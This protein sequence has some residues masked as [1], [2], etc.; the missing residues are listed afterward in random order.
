M[1]KIVVFQ[2]DDLV[3]RAQQ[4][5]STLARQARCS[6]V[7]ALPFC[8]AAS[9]TRCAIRASS[10]GF[11]TWCREP[12]PPRGVGVGP[13]AVARPSIRTG[14]RACRVHGVCMLYT[15]HVHMLCICGAYMVH[16]AHVAEAPRLSKAR[17]MRHRRR[18][19]RHRARHRARRRA[20]RHVPRIVR[21]AAVAWQ[22][23]ELGSHRSELRVRACEGRAAIARVPVPLRRPAR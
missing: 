9:S 20:E 2:H 22:R 17:E 11:I 13:T 21:G 18:R 12:Q 19:A 16:K 1:K 6:A 14:A 7:L 8:R 23:A 5:L 4:A 10:L 3:M 15:Q